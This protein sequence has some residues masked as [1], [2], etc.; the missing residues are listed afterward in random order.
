MNWFLLCGDCKK[1]AWWSLSHGQIFILWK[2][3]S[4]KDLDHTFHSS[5]DSRQYPVYFHQE[6]RPVYHVYHSCRWAPNYWCNHCRDHSFGVWVQTLS[7]PNTHRGHQLQFMREK[8]CRL[9]GASRSEPHTSDVI[10]DFFYMYII[11]MYGPYVFPYMW[12]H[13]VKKEAL[14]TYLIICGQLRERDHLGL[15]VVC[16]L[17]QNN[18]RL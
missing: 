6:S 18:T 1:Y 10:R 4:T 2:I 3:V 7:S 11:C 9:I 16:I 15:F 5:P 12:M 17:S 13:Q 14:G 8:T